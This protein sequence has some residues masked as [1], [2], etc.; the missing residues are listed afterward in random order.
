[1]RQADTE[2]WCAVSRPC[3]RLRRARE[4]FEKLLSR[5]TVACM[6][7]FKAISLFLT[8]HER[9]TDF[10]KA[11]LKRPQHFAHA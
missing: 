9:F 8:F 11:L 3:A 2:A 4:V 7:G 10:V 1:M 5:F 6:L